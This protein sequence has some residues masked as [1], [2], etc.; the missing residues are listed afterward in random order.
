MFIQSINPATG[1]EAY[2]FPTLNEEDLEEYLN[3]SKRSFEI[4]SRSSFEERTDLILN[5]AQIL[6][7]PKIFLSP[8]R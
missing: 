6:P 2:S 7:L 5:V 1:F 4:W 3:V 8:L